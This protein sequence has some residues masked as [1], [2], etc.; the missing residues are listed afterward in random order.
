[1]ILI[2]RVFIYL[3][4]IR[5]KGDLLLV[6]NEDEYQLFEGRESFGIRARR[7]SYCPKFMD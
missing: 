4:P 5:Q 6:D 1:M 7:D 2:F 3:A